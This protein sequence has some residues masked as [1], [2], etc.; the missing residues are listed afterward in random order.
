MAKK[1]KT[2][3]RKQ[4][5]LSG[6]SGI[7]SNEVVDAIKKTGLVLVGFIAGREVGRLI[8]KPNAD[9]TPVTG[10]KEYIAPILQAGGGV[11]LA[12]QKDNNLKYLGYGLTAAGLA[13][14]VS[15]VLK[16]DIVANGILK[17]LDGFD[18]GGMF[19]GYQIGSANIQDEYRRQLESGSPISGIEESYV[20]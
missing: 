16:K 9:G 10:F 6:A 4:H 8:V 3:T 18:L 13:E 17:G 7:K 2:H 12:T 20:S 19:S 11:F 5:K 1:R 14:G 15:K